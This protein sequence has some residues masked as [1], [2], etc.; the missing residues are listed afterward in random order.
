[1][2]RPPCNEKIGLYLLHYEI[3]IIKKINQS[4]GV[5]YSYKINNCTI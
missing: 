1:M 5:F 2:L 3:I 4:V